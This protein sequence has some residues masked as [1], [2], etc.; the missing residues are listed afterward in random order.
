MSLTT[1]KDGR[2]TGQTAKIDTEGRIHTYATTENE[3]LHVNRHNSEHFITYVDI[4]PTGANDYFFYLK[5]THTLDLIINWY[6]IWT[7]SAAEAIDLIRNPAG[8]PGNTTQ[9][10]PLNM[11]FGSN[12]SA[13]VE[14]Y[15]SVNMSGLS[16]GST[17][18][19]LRISGD[20]KDVVDSYEGGIILPQGT[21]IGA[22]VVNGAIP[23]EFTASFYYTR[24]D[25]T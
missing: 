14:N 13:T 25:V 22:R 10:T 18:D 3:E 4:T 20:G 12:K 9:L 21:S 6:R 17:L 19:R 1:L 23:L 2:G 15:E 5:N 7:E 24:L 16:G 8:T 11:H